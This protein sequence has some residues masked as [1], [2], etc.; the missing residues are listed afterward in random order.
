MLRGEYL[1]NEDIGERHRATH[2][3]THLAGHQLLLHR[4]SSRC[5]LA[6]GWHI[7]VLHV[8]S[9]NSAAWQMSSSMRVDLM[10]I[11]RL[12][13]LICCPPLTDLA[14]LNSCSNFL[15]AFSRLTKKYDTR[16]V[17]AW[18]MRINLIA[19][20]RFVYLIYTYVCVDIDRRWFGA[21]Q[22]ESNFLLSISG[23]FAAFAPLRFD[24]IRFCSMRN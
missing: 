9:C 15:I 16:I 13:I 21:K 4:K 12:N 10:P 1:G 7:K 22:S 2:R 20:Q 8:A 23:W 14:W 3:E 17:E 19:R 18:G 5:C 6:A 11:W 24:L